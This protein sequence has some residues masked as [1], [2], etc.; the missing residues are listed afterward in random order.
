KATNPS[1]PDEHALAVLEYIRTSRYSSLLHDA[2]VYRKKLALAVGASYSELSA[3][4]ELYSIYAVVKPGSKIDEVE[5]ALLVEIDR[6]KKEGPSATEMQKAKNQVEARH[7]FEQD[8][9]FRQAML[10]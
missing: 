6:L 8:S 2:L 7:V 10:L 9:I 4:P 3:D 5:K 1:N